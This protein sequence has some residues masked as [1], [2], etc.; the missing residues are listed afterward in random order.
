MMFPDILVKRSV[1]QDGKKMRR[2][3]RRVSLIGG[4]SRVATLSGMGLN[5]PIFRKTGGGVYTT[6]A[7]GD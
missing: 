4:R 6:D 7:G 5:A 2:L 1:A 3:R